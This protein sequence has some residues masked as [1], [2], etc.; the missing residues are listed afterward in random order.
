VDA[1]RLQGWGRPARGRHDEERRRAH[2]AL[3]RAAPRRTAAPNFT[4][5]PDGG[6]QP[7][8]PRVAPGDRHQDHGP[9]RVGLPARSPGWQWSQP[10][11]R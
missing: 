4:P 2:V 8:A 9:H 6:A 5:A 3:S 1:G 11:V 7:R 10:R